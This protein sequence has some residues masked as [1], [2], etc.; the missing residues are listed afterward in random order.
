[1]LNGLLAQL[2]KVTGAKF[3]NITYTAKGTGEKARHHLILGASTT[4]LY[5]KDLELL[6]GIASKFAETHGTTS[7][8]YLATME[9]I[10]SRSASLT[11]GV[12][13]N[14]EYT[15]AD[16]YAYYEGLDGVKVH[17]ETGAL[18]FNGLAQSKEVITAGTYKKVN[19]SPKTLAKKAIERDLPSGKFR[20]F[21]LTNVS[22]AALNGN[23]L[24]VE[25]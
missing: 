19:S 24:E 3:A 5:R 6:D 22:R 17:K 13:N 10:T 23:I 18:Y 12:G 25:G 9:L 8:E 21:A 16:T 7:P 1:M 4:E 2:A 11:L 20:T 15:N 14:P